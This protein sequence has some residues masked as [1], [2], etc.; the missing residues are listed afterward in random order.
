M[1]TKLSFL[2]AE[3]DHGERLDRYLAAKADDLSRARIKQLI[4]RGF[5]RVDS[6]SS[7]AGQKLK[8]G[9]AVELTVPPDVPLDMAPD[10]TV[11]FN[12][13]YQDASIIVVDK[14]P[15]LV[16][17]PAAGHE[18]GTLVHGLLAVCNDLAGIGGRSDRASFT[19][20]T[21]TRPG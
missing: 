12:I 19:V 13:L 6:E 3:D 18:N 2:V 11:L 10:P 14:P 1:E 8:T 9:Q 5:C 21:R 15:G 4:D 20:W 17:H 7:K 16:V